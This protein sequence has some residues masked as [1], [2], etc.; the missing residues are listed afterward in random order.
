MAAIEILVQ[1]GTFF[2][3]ND[4]DDCNSAISAPGGFTQVIDNASVVAHRCFENFSN[5]SPT[6]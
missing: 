2:P 4:I 6:Q 1:L 5:M 3:G